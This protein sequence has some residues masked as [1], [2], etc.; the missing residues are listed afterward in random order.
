MIRA[1]LGDQAYWDEFVKFRIYAISHMLEILK[2][3]PGDPNYDPQ[4]KFE[5]AQENWKCLLTRYSRGDPIS[6][7]KAYFPP[8]LDA[9]EKSECSG[10][11]VWTEQQQYT[12][13]TW[14]VNLD[15]YIDCFWL[16]GLALTLEIP[17]DQPKNRS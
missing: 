14:A 9:W 11:S 10:Q 16:V 3:P 2:Q 17:D 6:D 5:L 8:L 15:H 7:L 12:R 1:P 4:Y 13:H